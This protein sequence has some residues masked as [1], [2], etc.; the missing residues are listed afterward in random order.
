MED[1]RIRKTKKNLKT[2][3][4]T[5]LAEQPFEKISIT[6]LCNRAE[7]SRITF[8]S[9][10]SDKYALV[11]EIFQDMLALGTKEYEKKQNETNLS[12]NEI[13][14]YCNIMDTIMEVYYGYFDFFRHTS[15]DKNPYLAFAFY[16]IVLET[17]EGH[18]RRMEPRTHLKYSAKKIAGFL[19]YGM[20]GFIN[21]SHEEKVPI[22]QIR[23]EAKSLLVGVLSSKALIRL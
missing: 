3:L 16:N 8:Y 18:T 5:M 22:E 4:I 7:I 1:K 2:M 6:E 19:C 12:R 11:D 9:H 23:E 10:Y 17:V 13:K 15:P 21:E 20:I 14:S